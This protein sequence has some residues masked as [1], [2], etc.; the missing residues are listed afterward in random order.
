M[1]FNSKCANTRI[2]MTSLDQN[3]SLFFMNNIYLKIFKAILH[4]NYTWRFV[5]IKNPYAIWYPQAQKYSRGQN[6]LIPQS[7]ILL[8]LIVLVLFRVELVLPR[9]L[10]VL[11]RVVLFCTRVVLCCFV[12]YSCCV[13]LSC[14]VTLVFF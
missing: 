5:I 2:S 3:V 8:Y 12:L 11:S 13:V 4:K 10:L 9:V 1:R 14:D 6:V 7:Y